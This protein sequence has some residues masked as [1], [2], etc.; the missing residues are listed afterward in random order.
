MRMINYRT[1]I[2]FVPQTVQNDYIF[3]T[4]DSLFCASQIGRVGGP[5]QVNI[6][7]FSSK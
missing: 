6:N 7:Y 3:F 2:R 1:C 5:Q 4:N